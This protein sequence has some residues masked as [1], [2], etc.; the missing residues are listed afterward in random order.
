MVVRQR[1]TGQRKK[2]GAGLGRAL[3]DCP[4]LWACIG[5]LDISLTFGGVAD[6]SC[7]TCEDLNATLILS[8]GSIFEAFG[9][10]RYRS[11][12]DLLAASCSTSFWIDCI[13]IDLGDGTCSLY[14]AIGQGSSFATSILVAEFARTLS[15][16]EFTDLCAGAATDV[17]IDETPAASV[18]DFSSATCELTIA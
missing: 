6:D 7:T 1:Q 16:V 17:P 3:C 2:I 5:N 12:G 9:Y 4:G 10:C 13:I 11:A 18:C 8:P 14:V 15:A